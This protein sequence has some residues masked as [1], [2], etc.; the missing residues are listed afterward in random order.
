MK[1]SYSSEKLFRKAAMKRIEALPFSAFFAIQQVAIRGTPDEL[2]T[3]RGVFVALEFKKKKGSVAS[4]LQVLNILKINAAGGV[5]MFLEPSNFEAAFLLLTQLS[6][7]EKIDRTQL[8]NFTRPGFCRG[9]EKTRE[10][11]G[12]P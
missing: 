11:R 6:K 5:G 3:I 4:A 8:Q 10:L 1:D 12:D 9:D 7:G 2:G